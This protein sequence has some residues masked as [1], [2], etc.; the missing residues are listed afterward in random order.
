[1]Q[2]QITENIVSIATEQPTLAAFGL[3]VQETMTTP[4]RPGK[5]PRPVWVVRGNIF[6]LEEFFRSIKGRKFRGAW[7]FFED[8]SE[9]I[10]D[11]VQSHGRQ[12]YAEQIES[13]TQRKFE[14]AERYETYAA[15]AEARAEMRDK[16]AHGISSAIPFGQ[17]ILVGHHSERRHRRDLERIRHNMEKSVEESNKAEYLKGR[18]FDLSRAQ[19]RLENRRYIG[20]RIKESEKAVRQLSKW[21]EPTN[22]RLLQAQ[23]KLQYWQGCLAQIEAKQ[24]EDGHAI[25]SPET[26]KVGDLI[27][28]K[29]SWMPVVRV[30]KKTVTVSH[31]LDIPS[32]QYKIE[33]TRIEKFKSKPIA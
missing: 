8:P 26:I 9:K 1:M 30:N 14:K 28:Y 29:R 24:T 11:H 2:N 4:S 27:L 6:G 12:S 13:E 7:S 5:K 31:W 3:Q 33:F 18:A 22:P 10:L 25:A 15:N 20:N 23:E 16:T 19:E 21:A 32:F 17:P